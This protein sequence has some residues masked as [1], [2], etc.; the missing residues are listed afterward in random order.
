MIF[1]VA[2]LLKSAVGTSLTEEIDEEQVQL[3]N[4][5]QVIGPVTGH[6]RM[7]RTNQCI[8]VDGWVDLTLKLT[9]TRCLTE[10]EQPIHVPFEERFYPTIDVITGLPVPRSDEDDVFYI[11]A[12]HQL[13]LTEAIRQNILVNIPMATLCKED[14]AGL[15]AQCGHNLNEGPCDCQPEVE[16]ERLSILRTW[17]QNGT[18]S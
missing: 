4:D 2:Q 17:L 12:H 1:N 15:C 13:D 3:D 16:D 18:H 5:L 7:R 9:C 8:L 14:C 10:F 11:D 6:I